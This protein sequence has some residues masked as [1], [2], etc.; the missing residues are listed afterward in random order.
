[1]T[2]ARAWSDRTALRLASPHMTIPHLPDSPESASRFDVG[3][4][5]DGLATPARDGVLDAAS[6]RDLAVF[7]E[8]V[9][10]VPGATLRRP[11]SVWRGD[12]RYLVDVIVTTAADG[13]MP[14]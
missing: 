14:K 2:A 13:S 1:M 6:A 10:P 8:A 12:T 9:Q 5:L 7:L 3:A 11:V 4:Q